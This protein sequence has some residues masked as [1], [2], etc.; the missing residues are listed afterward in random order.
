LSRL[1]TFDVNQKQV[2]E[3]SRVVEGPEFRDF[4]KSAVEA[5]PEYG[6]VREVAEKFDESTT[7]RYILLVATNDWGLANVYYESY[8]GAEALWYVAREVLFELGRFDAGEFARRV[9]GRLR[10]ISE[11]RRRLFE[12]VSVIVDSDEVSKVIEAWIHRKVIDEASLRSVLERV[13]SAIGRG[14][15]VD[16]VANLVMRTI[17]YVLESRGFK[18]EA[19]QSIL[20]DVH[21]AKVTLRLGLVKAKPNPSGRYLPV[22]FPLTGNREL[23]RKTIKVWSEISRASGIRTWDID[24]AL[25]RIGR[26]FCVFDDEQLQYTSNIHSGSLAK[27]SCPYKRLGL[28]LNCPFREVCESYR[29]DIGIRILSQRAAGKSEVVLFVKNLCKLL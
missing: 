7:I 1:F 26:N 22:G 24:A 13:R 2:V 9:L 8:R 3:V 23:K 14:L 17:S 5:L 15:P 25:W 18:A 16:K 4:V 10:G 28:E 20:F 12:K 21:V 29:G 19:E 6:A 11:E 27:T